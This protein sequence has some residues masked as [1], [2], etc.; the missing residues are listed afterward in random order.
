MRR[1][2]F[3]LA[4]LAGA[5]FAAACGGVESRSPTASARQLLTGPTESVEFEPA[6][7]RQS[8]YREVARSSQLEAGR[9][10][11]AFAVFP[12]IRDDEV[13]A[14]PGL[15]PRMD[16]FQA[17]DAGGTLQ[18][19]F[20]GLASERWPEDGRESL[21]GLSEREAAELVARNLL[22]LW[23]IEPKGTVRVDR[24]PGA[25]YAAAYANGAFRLNPSF[26]YMAAAVSWSPVS[27]P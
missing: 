3:S 6:H 4:V 24:A 1:S 10:A 8:F 18:L 7:L 5:I 2:I 23:T 21:Q 15:D 17:P 25:P 12:I 9:H 27:F 14:G 22:V 13:V 20:E 19:T 26:L 16:L 11:T